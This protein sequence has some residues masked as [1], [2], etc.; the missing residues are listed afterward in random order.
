MAKVAYGVWRDTIIDNRDKRVF[1]IEDHPDLNA[2]DEFDPGNPVKIFLGHRGLLVFDREVSLVRSLLCYFERICAESCGKCTPCRVG[3]RILRDR[4]SEL[5][6]G[7]AGPEVLDEMETL[8]LQMRETS[9]CGL[10]Q[11]APAALIA[12]LAHFRDEFEAQLRSGPVRGRLNCHTYVTAPCI[13][14]CPAKVDVPR[15][16]D[17]VKDGKFTPF[18][19]RGPAEVSHGRHLRPGLRAFLRDGLPPHPGRRS[20]GH[21]G[22]QALRGRPRTLRDRQVVRAPT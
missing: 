5:A 19:G 18:G 21:Q 4:L 13:E 14:A 16:I 12:L 20:R 1:E 22:A 3:T 17:Y 15:Y 10:G 2:F 9:L 11:T 7:K 6:R 8:A